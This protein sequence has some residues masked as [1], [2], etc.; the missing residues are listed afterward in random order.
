VVLA[1]SGLDLVL[2]SVIFPLLVIFL[3]T[4]CSL[5]EALFSNR[6]VHYAG[7]IS[8]S[9]YLSHY[10]FLGISYRLVSAI[11]IGWLGQHVQLCIFEVLLTFMASMALYH[12]VEVPGKRLM[13]LRYPKT[14][15]QL[16]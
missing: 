13:S 16:R 10:L 6:A 15:P 7:V 2:C 4:G 5:G 12:F 3:A 1:Y 8:Y 9:L 11:N 14:T